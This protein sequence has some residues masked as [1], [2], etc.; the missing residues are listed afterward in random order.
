[1]AG[2]NEEAFGQV[3]LTGIKTYTG[4]AKTNTTTVY[5]LIK[6]GAG[7]II[8]ATGLTMPPDDETGYAK[9]ALFIDTDIATGTGGL[10]CNK[11]TNTACAFTLVTQG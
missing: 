6:D 2:N 10:Y 4:A 7:D 9:G 8:L 3:I 1:M 5:V 11:G